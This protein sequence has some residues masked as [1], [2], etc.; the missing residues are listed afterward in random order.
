MSTLRKLLIE[1][2]LSTPSL[3]R[4]Y[5]DLLRIQSIAAVLASAHA[6]PHSPLKGGTIP[7]DLPACMV[8]AVVQFIVCMTQPH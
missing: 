1:Q 2:L 8:R 4:I 7:R 5:L 3:E 6:P